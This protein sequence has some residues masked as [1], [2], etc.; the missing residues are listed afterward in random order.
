MLASSSL[1]T[2]SFVLQL[3][4]Q[5]LTRHG[6]AAIWKLHVAAA[7][8]YRDGDHGAAEMLI[9]AAEVVEGL[10]LGDAVAGV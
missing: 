6:Q 5:M 1:E 4:A 9:D 2:A 3:A 7:A 10:W 8:R